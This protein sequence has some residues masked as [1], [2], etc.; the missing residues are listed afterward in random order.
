MNTQL[1]RFWNEIEQSDN[2]ETEVQNIKN[3]T[4]YM[5][6]KNIS[7]IVVVTDTL[8]NILQMPK[9]KLI[10]VGAIKNVRLIVYKGNKEIFKSHKWQPK[11]KENIYMFFYE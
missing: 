8:E 11:N 5:S 9:E 1:V 6:R 10:D 4:N 3:L 7:Y 2:N